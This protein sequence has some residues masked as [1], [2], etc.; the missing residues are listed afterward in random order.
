MAYAGTKGFDVSEHNG[1][2]INFDEMKKQGFEFVIIRAGYGKYLNQK[3]K[4]FEDN[5]RKAQKAGLHI[6]AYWYSYAVT[7]Q[8][9]LAEVAVFYEIIKNKKF[10]FPVYLDIEEMKTLKSGKKN[11]D[12][13]VYAF[14]NYLEQRKFFAGFYCSKFWVLNS[15]SKTT[16]E[17]FAFWLAEWGSKPTY[18]E[19]FGIWQ[20]GIAKIEN[21][22]IVGNA[23]DNDLCFVDYPKIIANV[24]YNNLDTIIHYVSEN[25]T[26]DNIC[27]RYNI[28]VDELLKYNK[29]IHTGDRL[30]IKG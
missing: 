3:D 30:I 2:E 24:G 27:K 29:L 8:E 17:R 20:S 1:S 5:Y 26:I 14:C 9:A 4:C 25:D 13:I 22:G 7:P 11:C 18:T 23:I 12:D 21:C 6:G 16:R 10:D 19:Q 28:T 15:F